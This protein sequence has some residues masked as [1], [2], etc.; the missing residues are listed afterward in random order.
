MRSRFWSLV[1]WL[2]VATV[3][4]GQKFVGSES[5]AVNDAN[6]PESVAYTVQGTTLAAERV[7]RTQ[8]QIMEP[9]VVPY[10]IIFVPHWQYVYATEM[11]HLHVPTGMSSKIFTHLP[12]RSVYIDMD[13]CGGDEW[14]GHNLAHELGHLETQSV[15]ENDAERAASKYRKRLKSAHW[16]ELNPQE[17]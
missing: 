11:L 15:D 1:L 2:G 4:Q 13:R 10:R 5:L 14:L 7:I 8:I 16:Q 12:S 6:A 3:A 17:H 9:V